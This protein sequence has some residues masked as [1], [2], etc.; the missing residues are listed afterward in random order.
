MPNQTFFNLPANKRKALTEIAIAEFAT[1]DYN[2]ASISRI[3]ANGKIA[4]GSFYQYFQDKKDLYL[5]LI[6]LASQERIAFLRSTDPPKLQQGFFRYLRWLL[7]ASAQ[8]DLTHPKIS[9]IINGAVYGN[10]PFRDEAIERTKEISLD[11][12]KQLISQGIEKG[13]ISADISPDLAAYVV[14]TLLGNELGN[15]I[16]AQMN[17]E[18]QKLASAEPLEVDMQLINKVFDDLVRVIETGMSSKLDVTSKDLHMNK[19]TK[20]K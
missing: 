12:I 20:V 11:Y 2:S 16:L 4:K 13:D 1:Y 7:G 5:H 14:S 10:L 9:R 3:V 6:E 17:I 8:F 15:F 19:L 18:P